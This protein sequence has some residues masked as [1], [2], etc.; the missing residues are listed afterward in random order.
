VRGRRGTT[1]ASRRTPRRQAV[2]LSPVVAFPLQTARRSRPG[3]IMPRGHAGACD[4][5]PPAPPKPWKL[6][7]ERDMARKHGRFPTRPHRAHR[8]HRRQPRRLRLT[9]LAFAHHRHLPRQQH[10]PHLRR[11]RQRLR[12]RR[13][14]PD[15]RHDLRLQ[16]KHLSEPRLQLRSRGSL[17]GHRPR[18]GPWRGRRRRSPGATPRKAS[19]AAASASMPSTTKVRW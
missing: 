10:P 5:K 19:S 4:A 14:H 1:P 18:P 15:H 16:R 8:H 12:G 11:A 17:L 7:G 9:R 13:E 6:P 2:S 3:A